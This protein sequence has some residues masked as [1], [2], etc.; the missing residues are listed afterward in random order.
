MDR[1]DS[2]TERTHRLIFDHILHVL[3]LLAIVLSIWGGVRLSSSSNPLT[4]STGV[5]IAGAGI[6]I[7]LS[8]YVGLSVLAILTVHKI[9]R[10][11]SGRLPEGKNRVLVAVIATLPVL[12]VRMLYSILSGFRMHGAF[13]I[14]Y[15]NPVIY[16]CMAVLEEIAI[17]IMYLSVGVS[18]PSLKKRK[19]TADRTS[20]QNRPSNDPENGLRA[21]ELPIIRESEGKTQKARGIQFVL[22]SNQG[23]FSFKEIGDRARS[24]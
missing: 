22:V 5:K 12:F 14:I 1:R 20:L 7:L 21:Q 13:S 23:N 6:I 19:S 4:Q 3:C 16:L 18:T 15:G 17:V 8:V 10:L 9:R 11:P 2:V 24:S